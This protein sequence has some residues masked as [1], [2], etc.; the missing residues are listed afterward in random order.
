MKIACLAWGSLLWKTG[1]LILSTP[2]YEDGPDLPLEFCRVGDNG[3]LSTA[4]CEGAP[5]QTSWWAVLETGSL[6]EAREQL[7]QREEIDAH[8]PEWIGTLPSATGYPFMEPIRAWL[9]GREID[10]VVWTALPP[11]HDDVEGQAPNAEQAVDYLD[12]LQGEKGEHAQDYLR[13]VP[14]RFATPFR[15]EIERRLGWAPYPHADGAST[16]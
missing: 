6:D 5:L 7:R 1:P 4:L 3:E 8:R 11:R 16:A 14:A 9:A 12:G 2:W 15:A 10:A 13:R